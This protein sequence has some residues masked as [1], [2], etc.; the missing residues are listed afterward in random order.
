MQP[1]MTTAHRQDCKRMSA[2]YPTEDAYTSK[3]S[4]GVLDLGRL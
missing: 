4:L 1:K 2:M 3:L